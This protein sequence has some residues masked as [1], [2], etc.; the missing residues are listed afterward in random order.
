[1]GYAP[2]MRQTTHNSKKA[3]I[4]RAPEGG[5]PRELYKALSQGG[6]AVDLQ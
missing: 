1:M 2:K 5:T 3:Q 6:V 4:A